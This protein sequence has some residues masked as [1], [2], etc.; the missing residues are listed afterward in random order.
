MK[1]FQGV[2]KKIVLNILKTKFFKS[3]FSILF[4][5]DLTKLARLHGT[6]KWGRHSYTPI[7]QEHFNKTKFKRINLLEIGVGGYDDPKSG[8]NSLRMWK[9]FFPF[10]RIFSI[11][12]YEKSSLQEKRIKIFKGDQTDEAFLNQI[13]KEI[14]PIDIIIDD[15]SHINLHIIKTFNTLFPSLKDG[16]I[17]VV[18]DV[19]TSYWKAFGGDSED[20]ENTNTAMNFFKKLTDGLNHKEFIKP[21]Y[22][23][24]YYD[25]KIVS[26][27]FFHNLIL[28]YKGNNNED[29]NKVVNNAEFKKSKQRIGSKST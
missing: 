20:L 27:H 26:M 21:N 25:K 2:M 13:V 22:E 16:G 12:I 29:S 8:G 15:G 23:S 18:E 6:D 28:I 7:Y 19:Q 9:A 14:G 10:A 11:D 17:Y 4:L 3:I 5:F 24:S 1:H